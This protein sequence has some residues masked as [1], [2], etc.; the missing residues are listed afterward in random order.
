VGVGYRRQCSVETDRFLTTS[1][2]QL[3]QSNSGQIHYRR[4][5]FSSLL[6]SKCGNILAKT[7]SLRI[8]LDI[9]GTPVC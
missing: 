6:K 3:V 7:T 8:I 5:E 2:V 4:V 1:G 9:D